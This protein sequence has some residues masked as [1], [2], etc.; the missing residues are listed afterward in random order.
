[1]DRHSQNTLDWIE[2][3]DARLGFR[4]GGERSEFSFHSNVGDDYNR[5][6]AAIMAII[7]I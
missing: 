4:I 5:L 2:Q 1:M 6:G 7:L 3:N